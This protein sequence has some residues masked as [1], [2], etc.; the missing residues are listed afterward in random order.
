MIVIYNGL[1]ID[2]EYFRAYVYH[3][4]GRKQLANTWDE[5]QELLASGEWFIE[6]PKPL[7]EKRKYTKKDAKNG[8][9]C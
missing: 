9:D 6:K 3:P 4:D 8:A 2:S 5:H 1:R 7:K